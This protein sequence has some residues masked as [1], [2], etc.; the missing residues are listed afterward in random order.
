[1]A[2][3]LKKYPKLESIFQQIFDK[4]RF[5]LCGALC[6]K[7]FPKSAMMCIYEF[8]DFNKLCEFR[9]LASEG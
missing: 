5:Y 1:M 2:A 3:L 9:R 4:D 7:I 8:N 6:G